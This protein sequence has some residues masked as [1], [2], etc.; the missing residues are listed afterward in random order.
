MGEGGG[1][2]GVGGLSRRDAVRAEGAFGVRGRRRKISYQ[3]APRRCA[4]WD[5]STI[6]PRSSGLVNNYPFPSG[7]RLMRTALIRLA[8]AV[9]YT[10]LRISQE[11]DLAQV[12]SEPGR[13]KHK[14]SPALVVDRA[15]RRSKDEARRERRRKEGVE[16][17]DAKRLVLGRYCATT[18]FRLVRGDSRYSRRGRSVRVDS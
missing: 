10:R 17:R 1:G 5:A 15:C 16:L 3:E 6:D 18:F 13:A 8:G 12:L 7:H 4:T 11:Q 2:A 9:R 14:K